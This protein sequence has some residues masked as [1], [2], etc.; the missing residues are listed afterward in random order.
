VL[1]LGRA[2]RPVN[3]PGRTA[4]LSTEASL[5]PAGSIRYAFNDVECEVLKVLEGNSGSQ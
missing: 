5:G 1:D 3:D 2:S 4:V